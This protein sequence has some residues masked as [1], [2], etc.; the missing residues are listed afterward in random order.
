[1]RQRNFQ[2]DIGAKMRV[3]HLGPHQQRN[4]QR[5]RTRLF[6][7]GKDSKGGAVISREAVVDHDEFSVGGEEGE[8]FGVV[9]FGEV[10]A[11]VETDVVQCHRRS[12]AV[13]TVTVTVRIGLDDQILIQCQPQLG[14]PRQIRFH[15]NA[16]VNRAVHHMPVVA[17]NHIQPF[18]NIHKNLILLILVHR[19]ALGIHSPNHRLVHRVRT[20]RFGINHFA[21]I[22]HGLHDNRFIV[23]ERLERLRPRQLGISVI[24]HFVQQFV[25]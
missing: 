13:L 1:M 23:H 11:I 17:K 19:L 21:R 7:G 16:S 15:L 24:N 20:G 22:R 4:L 14:I 6:D 3:L 10:D 8:G 12:A 18:Q 2:N 25:Q 5:A 9:E